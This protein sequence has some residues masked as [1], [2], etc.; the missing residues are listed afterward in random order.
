M[1][2]GE[3][4]RGADGVESGESATG[5]DAGTARARVRNARLHA[6]LTQMELAR[7]LGK[8]QTFVSHAESGLARIGERYVQAVLQ[9]CG[10]AADWGA[11]RAYDGP[12]EGWA[13]PPEE[14]AGLDPET[15]EPVR[16]GS[17][18]DEELRQKY[19]W[20]TGQ[21]GARL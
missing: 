1:G 18:R 20:W 13:I 3:D 6:G 15:L 8:S 17:A 10:L 4:A 21:L 5:A 9:A 11:P 7:R 16:R 2:R 12:V 19:V 14:R